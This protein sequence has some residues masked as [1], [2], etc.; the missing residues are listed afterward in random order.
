MKAYPETCRRDE[1]GI[2]III[3]P[4]SFAPL[5]PYF[6]GMFFLIL[7]FDAVGGF[8]RLLGPAYSKIKI[9]AYRKECLGN[10]S[11]PYNLITLAGL[12][13]RHYL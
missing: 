3:P 8:H 2:I 5:L 9:L 4:S 6:K 1:G 13:H 10:Q 7:L 11:R 12:T